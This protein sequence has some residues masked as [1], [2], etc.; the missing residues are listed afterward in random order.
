[1]TTTVTE[2]QIIIE[3]LRRARKH[4]GEGVTFSER[5]R[6]DNRINEV[7]EMHLKYPTAA[8]GWQIV[9]SGVWV[10]ENAPGHVFDC[11]REATLKCRLEYDDDEIYACTVCAAL[12][13]TWTREQVFDRYHTGRS[14]EESPRLRS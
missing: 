13:N 7:V 14:R 5:L 10:C 11:P 3:Y 12:M 1:M 2:T 6:I 4:G 9:R 8:Y